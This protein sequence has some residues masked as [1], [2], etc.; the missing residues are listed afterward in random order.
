MSDF[1]RNLVRG[2]V[3]LY[4][5]DE[6]N[7]GGKLRALYEAGPLAF[8]CAQANAVVSSGSERLLDRAPLSVHERTPLF[9]G[10]EPIIAEIEDALAGD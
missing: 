8:V 7:P 6:K 10:P 5:A 3:F 1:H 4:P 2:G 9:I